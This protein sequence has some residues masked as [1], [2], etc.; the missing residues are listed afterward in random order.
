MAWG[1]IGLHGSPQLECPS[2][3]IWRH[4][5]KNAVPRMAWATEYGGVSSKMLY[6]EWFLVPIHGSSRY[7]I[8]HL[9]SGSL[10]PCAIILRVHALSSHRGSRVGNWQD[11]CFCNLGVPSSACP[12]KP[13]CLGSLLGPRF[14]LGTPR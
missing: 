11:G 6:L 1:G 7:H 10:E 4:Q 13:S 12:H 9:S 5:V 2:T 14:F 8:L 3:Q